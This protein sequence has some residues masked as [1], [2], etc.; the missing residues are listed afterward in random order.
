MACTVAAYESAGWFRALRGCKRDEAFGYPDA[1]CLYVK[2][3]KVRHPRCAGADRIRRYWLWSMLQIYGWEPQYYESLPDD[4]PP[5]LAEHVRALPAHE[6][7]YTSHKT[8]IY[9]SPRAVT[10]RIS[11]T[12]QK[13]VMIKNILIISNH[14]FLEAESA[15]LSHRC[16]YVHDDVKLL[17]SYMCIWNGCQTY[18]Y[19]EFQ[20]CTCHGG[21]D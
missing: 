20:I 14:L 11:L 9:R 16:I 10:R 19:G 2:L 1:P 4:A 7:T 6:V 21:R 18:Y 15:K 5:D 13:G 8:Y 12:E 3:N 17:I